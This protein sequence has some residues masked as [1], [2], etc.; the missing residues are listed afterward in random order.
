MKHRIR[1]AGLVRRGDQ[2]LLVEQQ[3]P[4]N[5]HKR[6]TVPGG[7]LEYTDAD[8]F[9]GVEREIFEETGLLVRA[10]Q[11][12]YISEYISVEKSV[13]MLS[14]WI[15]C[16]PREGDDFGEPTLANTLEDDY[17]TGIGWW[18]RDQLADQSHSAALQRDEFW[19][20]L[21]LPPGQVIYLGRRTDQPDAATQA[22]LLVYP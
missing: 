5:G 20:H 17:I 14:L 7:G 9:A 6:W 19:A 11:V 8:I 10:G 18:S 15:D 22:P 1:V 21:H 13:L 3:N 2:L 16:F 4:D 12:R